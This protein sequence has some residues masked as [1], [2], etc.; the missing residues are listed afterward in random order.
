M[1]S[2]GA[3]LMIRADQQIKTIPGELIDV[4]PVMMFPHRLFT[5]G[6]PPRDRSNEGLPAKASTQRRYTP[7]PL[8]DGRAVA[9]A[10]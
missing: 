10:I 3:K 4:R 2:A 5:A 1:S 9:T 6:S 8:A 7:E